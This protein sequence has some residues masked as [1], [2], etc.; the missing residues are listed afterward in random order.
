MVPNQNNTTLP[1]YESGKTHINTIIQYTTPTMDNICTL[2]SEVHTA[3]DGQ[4]YPRD[5]DKTLIINDTA[6]IS[7]KTANAIIGD[8]TGNQLS[9][10]QLSKHPKYIKYGN[11]NFPANSE[12]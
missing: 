12:D 6:R 3:I 8:D 5:Y 10:R 1:G 11:N 2:S 7:V 4:I 9:Y